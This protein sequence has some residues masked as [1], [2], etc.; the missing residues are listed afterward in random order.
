MIHLTLFSGHEGRL[1]PGRLFYLT[2]CG[3][4]DVIRPTVA[5]QIL[6]QREAERNP[7]VRV[8]RPFFLTIFGSVDVTAPTLAEEFLDLRE[9]IRAGLLTPREW[10]RFAALLGRQEGLVSSLTLFGSFSEDEVPPEDEEVDALAVQQHLGN[11]PEPA[12]EVL[13]FGIGQKGG[14]RLSTIRRAMAV[15]S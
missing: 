14:E 5:R 9:M 13:R 6:M 15:A 12:A 11:I 3:G 10:D 4:C 8:H 7:A 2:F 1:L